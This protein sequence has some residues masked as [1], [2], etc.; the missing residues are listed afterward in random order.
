[1]PTG[2]IITGGGICDL[3]IQDNQK[4]AIFVPK[5]SEEKGCFYCTYFADNVCL[6]SG[7]PAT[8]QCNKFEE[9]V[10]DEMIIEDEPIGTGSCTI[11]VFSEYKDNAPFC[12]F[13]NEQIDPDGFCERFI[14]SME[15]EPL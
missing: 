12:S 6:L 5:V 13:K 1:M 3:W 7:K 8:K 15:G 14:N 9:L 2:T 4:S 11:C 10:I